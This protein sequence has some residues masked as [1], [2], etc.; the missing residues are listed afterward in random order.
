[1]KTNKNTLMWLLLFIVV[2]GGTILTAFITYIT[3]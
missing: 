1:M 2:A 3:Q